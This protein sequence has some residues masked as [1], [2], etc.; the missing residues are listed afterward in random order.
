M[1]IEADKRLAE[2]NRRKREELAQLAKA[3]SEPKITYYR[4]GAIEAIGT[5]DILSYC[6][7][8]FKKILRRLWFTKLMK[9]CFT[10]PRKLQLVSL[11]WSRL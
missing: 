8:Q 2:Y 5:S 9:L 3:Q 1:K 4:A 7:Y 11:K 6:V 10:D